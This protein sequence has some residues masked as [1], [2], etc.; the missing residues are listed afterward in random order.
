MNL[1]KT[2]LELMFGGVAEVHDPIENISGYG[3]EGAANHLRVSAQHLK[4]WAF[5]F[6]S[7]EAL[8]LKLI[9]VSLLFATEEIQISHGFN[10]TTSA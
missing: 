4:N 5:R 8:H 7:M 1:Q 6:L 3:D 2:Q 10:P 9:K